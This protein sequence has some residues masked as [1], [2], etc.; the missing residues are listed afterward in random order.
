MHQL[1]GWGWVRVSRAACHSST[2]D[3]C[4]AWAKVTAEWGTLAEGYSSGGAGLGVETIC[5]SWGSNSQSWHMLHCPI[6]HHLQ[7]KFRAKIMTHF[8]STITE[9]W[10]PSPGPFWMQGPG[11]LHWSQPYEVSPVCATL[12]DASKEMRHSCPT[13]PLPRTGIMSPPL[14]SRDLQSS[15]CLSILGPGGG[16]GLWLLLRQPL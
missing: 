11:Q 16:S 5:M 1:A 10:T 9:C 14:V 7:N 12:P 15:L 3:P 6:G 8:K 2:S 4:F 13:Q